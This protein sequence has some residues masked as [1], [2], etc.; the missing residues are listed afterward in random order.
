L[1]ID[2]LAAVIGQFSTAFF[3]FVSGTAR[4]LPI[5]IVPVGAARLQFI[6]ATIP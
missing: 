3:S 4:L 5:F 2:N 6:A 1:A